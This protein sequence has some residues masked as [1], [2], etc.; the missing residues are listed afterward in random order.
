M[1]KRIQFA[2]VLL[3]FMAFVGMFVVAAELDHSI[4]DERLVKLEE[5]MNEVLASNPEIT[6]E[7]LVDA[8]AAKFKATEACL[9]KK[10]RPQL[11][12]EDDSNATAEQKLIEAALEK[13][14]NSSM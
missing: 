10:E 1:K 4:S 3:T 2:F 14:P 8:V 11:V 12:L 13:Y 5:M 9:A 7:E 6:E